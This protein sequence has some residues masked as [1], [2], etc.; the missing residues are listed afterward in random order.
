MGKLLQRTVVEQPYTVCFGSICGRSDATG[1]Y[2]AVRAPTCFGI[3]NNIPTFYAI[4]EMYYS[5][6]G[7][8][9]IPVGELRMA[10]HEM[11]DVLNLPMG[12]LPYEEYFSCAKELAQMEKKELALH[13]K[14]R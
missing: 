4:L 9:F 2:E 10:L 14:Y 13:K 5:M 7:T 3:S 11:W 8:F 12:S 6:S 1:L